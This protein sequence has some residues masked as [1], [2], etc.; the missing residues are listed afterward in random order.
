MKKTIRDKKKLVISISICALFVTVAFSSVTAKDPAIDVG[1]DHDWEIIGN[2]VVTGNRLPYPMGNVGIGTMVP[3]EKLEVDGNIKAT[4]FIGDGSSLTGVV[5]TESDPV[6]TASPA[7]GISLMDILNWD[8]AFGWGDHA[9]AGYDT[10]IDSW[11]GTGDLYTTTGNVG[12]GT[13]NPEEELHIAGN[14]KNP[15]LL[16]KPKSN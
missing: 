2:N 3:S 4:S 5:S 14:D 15:T 11:I 13:T 16:I 1:Q 9:S 7:N 12:I 6:F 8:T 10:T